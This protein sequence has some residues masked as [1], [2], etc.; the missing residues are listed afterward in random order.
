MTPVDYWLRFNDPGE[1]L[2]SKGFWAMLIKQ[3]DTVQCHR[4]SF[5][6]PLTPSATS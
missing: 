2:G 5:T 6:K 4:E 3:D 1:P